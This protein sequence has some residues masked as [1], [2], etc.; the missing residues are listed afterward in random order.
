MPKVRGTPE[1]GGLSLSVLL[2][3]STKCSSEK[4]DDYESLPFFVRK[5]CGHLG[6]YF[7]LSS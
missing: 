4:R 1:L 7:T 3:N 5:R 6:L 2:T